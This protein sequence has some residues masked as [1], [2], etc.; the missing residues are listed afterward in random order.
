M[1]TLS[2]TP[3]TCRTA[4]ASSNTITSEAVQRKSERP[5][6]LPKFDSRT[7]TPAKPRTCHLSSFSTQTSRVL[8]IVDH[9]LQ[10]IPWEVLLN[11]ETGEDQTG[12]VCSRLPSLPVVAHMKRKGSIALDSCFFA[13]NPSG[14]LQNTEKTFA[15]WFQDIPGWDGVIG[16]P[17]KSTELLQ[18]LKARELFVY[19]GHGAGEQYLSIPKIRSLN[20]CASALLMG[21][22]S[23]KLRWNANGI[24][25]PAGVLLAYILAGCPLAIA[26]LWDV[27]DKDIDRYCG[28]LLNDWLSHEPGK[29]A[30]LAVQTARAACKLPF[31]IGAAP[32]C[33]G[34]PTTA[35]TKSTMQ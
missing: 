9:V 21:C 20:S 5:S 7:N 2:T 4:L 24:F 25:E 22:S 32:V 34:M 18:A 31:L 17:P 23:G 30:E 3:G 11:L 15:K 33:F 26:N 14:D 13:L 27:T 19:C 28:T 1:H 29:N 16:K 10:N 8:L 12:F 6:V 35:L